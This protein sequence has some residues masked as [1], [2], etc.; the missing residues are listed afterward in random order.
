MKKKKNE[1]T[2]IK[3]EVEKI[4]SD[5]KII[6]ENLDDKEK[7]KLIYSYS[8]EIQKLTNELKQKNNPINL[9]SENAD[10]LISLIKNSAD[11]WLEHKK[12]SIG[13]SINMALFA[14]IIIISIV[15]S[16]GWLT[17]VGKI[18]GSTF[19]FLLGLIVGYALTFLQNM[20]NPPH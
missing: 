15:G 16:A 3:Q 13:F 8:S 9:L 17:Y 6:V 10:N 2:D 19:T 4:T 12:T 14:A 11:K 1:K 20:I 7:T 5:D 18:D